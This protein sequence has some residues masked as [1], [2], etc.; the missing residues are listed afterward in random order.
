MIVIS[1]KRRNCVF[2]CGLRADQYDQI[3]L[4]V[5]AAQECELESIRELAIDLRIGVLC[6]SSGTVLAIGW[7]DLPF[8][9]CV[10]VHAAT[11]KMPRQKAKLIYEIIEGLTC[12][13]D[14]VFA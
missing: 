1:C 4:S 10:M 6:F 7:G 3:R 5:M 13:I 12:A 9:I 8:L 11:E 14:M 2:L